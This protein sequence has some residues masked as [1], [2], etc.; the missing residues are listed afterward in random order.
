MEH[1]VQ[2]RL[3]AFLDNNNMLSASQVSL[4]SVSQY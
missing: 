3:Q 4:P 1:A 2:V